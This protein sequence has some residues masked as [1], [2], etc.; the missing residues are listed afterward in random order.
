MPPGGLSR[1]NGIGVRDDLKKHY[2]DY[3][4]SADAEWRKLGAADKA[5]NIV[6]L[7]ESLPHSSVLEVGAG[8]GAILEKLSELGFG[9]EYVALEISSSGVEAIRSKRIPALVDSRVF[10]GYAIPFEDRA[11][12]LVVLSH[13]LEHAE[14]PRKLL[15]EAARVATHAF[16]EVPLEDTLRLASDFVPDETGHINEYSAR[17]IRRLVQTCGLDVIAQKVVI[18][19]RAVHRFRSGTMGVAAYHVKAAALRFAPAV[20]TQFLTYHSVLVCRAGR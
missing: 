17:S 20:A 8:D 16:V 2:G 9:R 13:V 6:S 10:D 1:M 18:P 4:R 12:D 19:S 7:C 14:Y 15:Y 5:L 3:Y 11:F